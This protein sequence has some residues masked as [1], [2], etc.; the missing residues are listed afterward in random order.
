[1]GYIYVQNI[2]VVDIYICDE[3]FVVHIYGIANLLIA[4]WLASDLAR[5]LGVLC[6]SNAPSPCSLF[7]S[8]Q[9]IEYLF[10]F[11]LHPMSGEACVV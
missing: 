5:S 6:W 8:I 11:S 2:C 10:W 4:D 9:D 1:M 3:Y 7:Y